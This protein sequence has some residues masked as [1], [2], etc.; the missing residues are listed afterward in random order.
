MNQNCLNCGH[1]L[2]GQFCYKCGQKATVGKLTS[3]SLLEEIF[4]F[5]THVEKGFLKTGKLLIFKPGQLYKSYLDGKRK[6]YHKP[7]S[8]LLIWIAVFVLIFALSEKITNFQSENTSTLLTNDSNT[9][10]L[11][12]KYRS[13]IEILILP[14]TALISWLIVGRRKLNYV[15]ILAVSFYSI[16]FL[17]ILLSFQFVIAL[18]FGI[19]FKTNSYDIVTVSI[20]ICWGIYCGYDF[21]KRY[22][23][24]WLLPRLLFS[25]LLNTLAY[26]YLE[27]LIVHL[28]IYLHI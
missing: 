10:A 11:I 9:S 4:H 13:I 16:S 1:P 27:K 23:I 22:Q 17:F 3:K 24:R 7:I 19:N 20:F 18:I 6:D 28:F 21:F 8:F 5:I 2:K 25:L 15:E 12:T 14:F 26:F